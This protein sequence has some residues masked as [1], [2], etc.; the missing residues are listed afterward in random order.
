MH[1]GNGKGNM[2]RDL[3]SPERLAT[4]TSPGNLTPTD[5]G[6]GT[7]IP[8]VATPGDG[9]DIDRRMLLMQKQSLVLSIEGSTGKS[10][11]SQ[12][13]GV[14]SCSCSMV[15]YGMVYVVLVVTVVVWY[16]MVWCMLC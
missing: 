9:S 2:V 10:P 13:F 14:S 12:G 6:T 3:R 5:T 1:I 15:W 4:L 16:G 11:F 8:T 7:P